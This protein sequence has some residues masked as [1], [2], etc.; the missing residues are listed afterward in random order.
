MRSFLYI[1]GMFPTTRYCRQLI[2]ILLCLPLGSFA[3]TKG[4]HW[5][6]RLAYGGAEFQAPYFKGLPDRKSSFQAGL[7]AKYG[8]EEWFGL[9]ADAQ[10]AY[11][12]GGGSGYLYRTP[13]TLFFRGTYSNLA[14]AV[15]VG[16]HFSIPGFTFRPYINGGAYIQVNLMNVESREYVEQKPS[17][18]NF[19][20]K[21]LDKTEAFSITT[22]ADIGVEM[23]TIWDKFIFFELRWQPTF[24]S[25]G[26]SDGSNVALRTTTL[27]A[28]IIF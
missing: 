20:K 22:Y 18:Q 21:R 28:G 1:S 7:V 17:Y 5:G 4:F 27:A 23:Y 9:R 8:I 6:A 25:I 2:F 14:L 19:S 24:N 11:S 26:S 12:Q 16:M 15:P 3:Q 10:L 13:D